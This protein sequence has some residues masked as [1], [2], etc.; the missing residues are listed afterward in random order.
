MKVD[1]GADFIVT[2]MF[3]DNSKYFSF[4]KKCREIGIKI[5]IIPGIK[6]ITNL[7]HIAFL[8]KFFHIDF[9]EALS[10]ELSKCT[11]NEQVKQVGLEWGIQQAKELKAN[12]VP[13]IHFYTMGKGESVKNIAE[14]IF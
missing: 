1:A 7:K 3:Y 6:P 9:P 14:H 8:P 11:T 10:I 12:D 13:V 4:V 2:Q 5:P